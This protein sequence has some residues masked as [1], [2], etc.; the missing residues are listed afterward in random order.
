MAARFALNLI[1]PG[2]GNTQR[3]IND[4]SMPSYRHSSAWSAPTLTWP[5]I[6]IN[7]TAGETGGGLLR[8]FKEVLNPGKLGLGESQGVHI[9]DIYPVYVIE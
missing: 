5:L 3:S 4:R 1:F 9:N 6:D 2:Q 7:Y 8:G